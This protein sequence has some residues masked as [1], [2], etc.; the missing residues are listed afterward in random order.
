MPVA[1]CPRRSSRGWPSV[2]A[3]SWTTPRTYVQGELITPSILHIRDNLN[4]VRSG[5]IAIKFAG[6]ERFD[7]RLLCDAARAAR[8]QWDGALSPLHVGI[9]A[10]MVNVGATEHGDSEPDYPRDEY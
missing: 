6:G 10:V 9:G 8:K 2:S 5:G 4:V 7:L 1:Q 3:Q